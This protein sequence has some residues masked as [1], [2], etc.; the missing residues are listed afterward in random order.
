M[1]RP[2]LFFCAR[3]I[4]PQRW[5][6]KRLTG[7][8]VPA[9]IRTAM[10]IL[11]NYWRQMGYLGLITVLTACA[12]PTPASPL[13]T[14]AAIIEITPAPTQDIDATATAY[15]AQLIPTVTPSGLYV[16]QEGDT[17]SKLA[18]EFGS[19]VEEIMAANG[20]TDPNALQAGQMVIIPSQIS[21][22][23]AFGTP[24]SLP[25]ISRLTQTPSTPTPTISTP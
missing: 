6:V 7:A 3:R 1:P 20:L 8:S 5:A 21:G 11:T 18:E 13:P 2:P 24:S 19:T 25:T 9:T 22:T 23:L 17:L 10:K 12:P 14:A 15:A 4:P 16:V